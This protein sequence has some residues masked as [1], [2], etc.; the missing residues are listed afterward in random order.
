[1]FFQSNKTSP[2]SMKCSTEDSKI[3]VEE[4]LKVR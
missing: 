2:K 1:M 4:D 3:R